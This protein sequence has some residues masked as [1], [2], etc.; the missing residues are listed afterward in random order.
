MMLLWKE[1]L[2]IESIGREVDFFSLGG[3][4]LKALEMIDQMRT[5]FGVEVSLQD[6]FSAPTI[7]GTSEF[8][9][10]AI[11]GRHL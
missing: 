7:K 6:F 4:S 1:N 9:A 5:L 2:E 10:S 3:D 11:K 8:L